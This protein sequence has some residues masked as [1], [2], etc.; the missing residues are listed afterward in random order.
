MPTS[1]PR[2]E[3]CRNSSVSPCL[4]PS[5]L[6]IPEAGTIR[7]SLYRVRSNKVPETV[8]VV[9]YP[10]VRDPAIDQAYE[11]RY[12]SATHVPVLDD[13]GDVLLLMQNVFDVAEYAET[14][15]VLCRLAEIGVVYAQGFII[16]RP[17]PLLTL[18]AIR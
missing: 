13:R 10:I 8:A 15:A 6:H 12:W 4:K 7:D 11:D 9:H 2:A 1:G 18:D 3:N 16:H 14:E 17:E 5:P